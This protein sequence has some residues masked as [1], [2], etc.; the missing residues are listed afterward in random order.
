[1]E[2][3]NIS[4]ELAP[5][6]K[7]QQTDGKISITIETA[8]PS[9]GKAT[10]LGSRALWHDAYE[11]LRK[12][13]SEAVLNFEDAA[14]M[15]FRL[16][17]RSSSGNGLRRPAASSGWQNTDADTVLSAVRRWF[18]EEDPDGGDDNNQDGDGDGGEVYRALVATK[19]L[20]SKSV[21]KSPGAYLAW[22]AVCLCVQVRSIPYAVAFSLVLVMI[23]MDSYSI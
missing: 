18:S 2:Q 22:S 10:E 5:G 9:D 11:N 1:M 21:Q 7:I 20:L 14:W 4:S 23:L 12:E 16:L 15:F 17:Q 3:L 8:R 6:V 19:S 13:C